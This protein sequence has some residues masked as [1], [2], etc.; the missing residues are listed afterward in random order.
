MIELFWAYLEKWG[1]NV[2]SFLPEV[3]FYAQILH[4][5]NLFKNKDMG[6]IIQH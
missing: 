3:W 2:L 5:N 6:L 1:E 4:F